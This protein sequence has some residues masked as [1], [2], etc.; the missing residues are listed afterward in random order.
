MIKINKFGGTDKN[1]LLLELS[2]EDMSIDWLF[3]PHKASVLEMVDRVR[4]T[5]TWYDI[6]GFYAGGEPARKGLSCV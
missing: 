4:E 3:R 2:C 5:S 1:I 6:S